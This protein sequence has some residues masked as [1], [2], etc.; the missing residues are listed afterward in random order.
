MSPLILNISTPTC[1]VKTYMSKF[2]TKTDVIKTSA[3]Y[4]SIFSIV[5]AITAT[6]GFQINLLLAVVLFGF[7]LLSTI[8]QIFKPKFAKYFSPVNSTILGA[9]ITK[10]SIVALPIIFTVIFVAIL[11]FLYYKNCIKVTEKFKNI[12]T[13]SGIAAI[14]LLLVEIF[15]GVFAFVG[16][17]LPFFLSVFII[18]VLAAIF[19]TELENV[20]EAIKKREP[21]YMAHFYGFNLVYTVVTLF[22][23]FLKVSN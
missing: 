4:L 13:I 5:A 7:L 14:V 3:T 17:I 11:L 10:S 9:A 8:Y 15:T 1:K 20:E 6:I 22:A 18:V 21:K 12:T 23:Q 19:F 16:G 2:I